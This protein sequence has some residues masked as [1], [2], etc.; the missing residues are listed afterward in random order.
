[1]ELYPTTKSARPS[2]ILQSQ[3]ETIRQQDELIE[4]LKS[5]LAATGMSAV[6]ACADWTNGMSPQARAV[7]GVLYTKY[8]RVV[9][10]EVIIEFLPGHD[11]VKERQLQVVDVIVHKLRKRFGH[12]AIFTERGLGFRLGEGFYDQLPKEH[13][14][15]RTVSGVPAED[16]NFVN[17]FQN[18]RGFG[19]A[20][21][22]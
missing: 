10:R 14:Q 3:R 1:M 17:E 9:P 15:A 8:P 5:A 22:A 6:P 4:V 21:R 16:P 2:E 18:P 20:R 7:I 11:H 13:R 19:P 12:E